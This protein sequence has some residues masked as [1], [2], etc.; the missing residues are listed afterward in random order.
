MFERFQNR[1]T[2][3]E[4]L[5]TGDYTPDEYRR[6]QREMKYI[7]AFFGE[8]RALKRTLLS[9]LQASKAEA[10]SILDVG[11]GSGGL[12]RA[13]DGWLENKN[14]LLVGAELDAVA[15]RSINDRSIKGV[16]CDALKLPFAESSFNNVFCSLFL[17]HLD[18]EPAIGL[19]KEMARVSSERIYVIDLNRHP[20]AY[21]AYKFFGWFLLQRFTLDDGALSIL[22]SRT[23]GELKKLAE[24]AGLT[25]IHVE[26]SR[27]N[28]LI[29]SAK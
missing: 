14:R 9:D 25:D 13:L 19:L 24:K 1:S 22:R 17:H 15:V 4:R 3:L 2:E 29:L 5:D 8:E 6:W 12:L 26:H 20:L 23:P 18:D 28:R 16:R 7:H 11:A 27:A 21:Y 10:V